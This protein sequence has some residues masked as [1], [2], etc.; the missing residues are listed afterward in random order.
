[1]TFLHFP[2]SVVQ[3]NVT[4]YLLLKICWIIK[5]CKTIMHWLLSLFSE[6]FDVH[7]ISP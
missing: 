3:Q 4:F 6:L 2:T 7:Y 5:L 1:M